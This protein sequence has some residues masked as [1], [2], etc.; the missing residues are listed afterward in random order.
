MLNCRDSPA[1]CT[2]SPGTQTLYSRRATAIPGVV[3]G[4][5]TGVVSGY[6]TNFTQKDDRIFLCE[7]ASAAP[8]KKDFPFFSPVGRPVQNRPPNPAPA[9]CLFSTR[10]S[11]SEVPERGYFGEE[12]CPPCGVPGEGWGGQGKRR[13]K[14]YTQKAD[15]ISSKTISGSVIPPLKLPSIIPET[16][17]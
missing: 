9:G 4:V 5:Q 16:M 13:K 11:R 2:P 6:Y 14:G 10:K 15:R 7:S 3:T 12:N 17:R 1:P 8:A